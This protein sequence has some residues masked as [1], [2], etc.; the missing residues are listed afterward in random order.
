MNDTSRKWGFIIIII[1]FKAKIK[2]EKK[3]KRVIRTT[4]KAMGCCGQAG[5]NCPDSI[6]IRVFLSRFLIFKYI[7][8]YIYEASRCVGL[9]I[10]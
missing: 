9:Q 6:S 3:K 2:A 1:I 8:V 5:H 10:G 4:T 7:Y